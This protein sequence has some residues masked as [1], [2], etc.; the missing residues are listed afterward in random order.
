M[1]GGFFDEMIS[2]APH[3]GASYSEDNATVLNILVHVLKGTSFEVSIQPFK[4]TRDGRGAFM[5]LTKHNLG[6]N[7]WENVLERADHI[8][9]NMVWNGRSN[10][11]PLRLHLA[12]HRESH[13]DMIR[14]SHHIAFEVPNEGT[15]VR[16]LLQSLQCNDPRIIVSAK[17]AILADEAGK[18]N[19]FEATA[20]FLLIAAPPTR[21]D[22][23]TRRISGVRNDFQGTTNKGSTGVE[24]RYHTTSEYSNLTSDQKAELFKWRSDKKRRKS[25]GYKISNGTPKLPGEGTSKSAFKRRKIS[26]IQSEV[27]RL[28][29]IVAKFTVNDASHE[30]K[31]E[32]GPNKNRVLFKP[33][34]VNK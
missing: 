6:T 31:K 7:R 26:A 25:P 14:A 33:S 18:K 29:E 28:K 24:L 1:F 15:R 2:C 3:Q 27:N 21:L 20:N 34:G 9:S 32:D 19:D 11:Y 13:N 23:D 12:K 5:A 30:E 8:V 10:R 22:S 4:R 17:T 16:K